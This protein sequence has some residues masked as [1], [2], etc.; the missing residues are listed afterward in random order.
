VGRK[1]EPL[2]SAGGKK[3]GR[4]ATDLRE[5]GCSD[6]GKFGSKKAIVYRRK[7]MGEKTG[8][9]QAGSLRSDE[10]NG[11]GGY[12]WRGGRLYLR[13]ERGNDGK[14]GASHKSR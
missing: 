5:G 9:Y 3:Q 7:K 12:S 13:K 4:P 10:K 2:S 1:K 8:T 6:P 11:I 14:G